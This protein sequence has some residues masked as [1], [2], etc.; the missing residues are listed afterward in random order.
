MVVSIG[1][2]TISFLLNYIQRLEI[3]FVTEI[4]FI[5]IDHPVDITVDALLRYGPQNMKR[6]HC[7]HIGVHRCHALITEMIDRHD[8]VIPE[9]FIRE[10]A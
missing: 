3:I 7:V 2:T 5:L 4:T 1:D 10:I 8:V 9:I 6:T